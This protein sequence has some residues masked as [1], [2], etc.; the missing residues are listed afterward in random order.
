MEVSSDKIPQKKILLHSSP[1]LIYLSNWEVSYN[2]GK[3]NMK[4]GV[5]LLWRRQ[6]ETILFFRI[7]WWRHRQN[8][9][10]TKGFI[11][12]L[13]FYYT[14]TRMQNFIILSITVPEKRFTGSLSLLSFLSFFTLYFILLL[15]SQ[16]FPSSLFY[17]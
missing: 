6:K 11:L 7:T 16:L 3:L 13:K 10:I 8:R 9:D 15:Y 2:T 5:I 17:L 4:F 14:I 1:I 12:F